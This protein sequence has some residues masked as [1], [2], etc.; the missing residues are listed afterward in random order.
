MSKDVLQTFTHL[1]MHITLNIIVSVVGKKNKIK[2]IKT[3]Q[4]FNKMVNLLRQIQLFTANITHTVPQQPYYT[5]TTTSQSAATFSST[6]NS[7]D[8]LA[9]IFDEN[10][11][12]VKNT[13]HFTC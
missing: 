8:S 4:N 9:Y 12:H 1:T 10:V 5:I 7:P 13:L 2:K 6:S 3:L 11:M